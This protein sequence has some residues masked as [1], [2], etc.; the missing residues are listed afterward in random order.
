MWSFPDDGRVGKNGGPH[1][2]LAGKPVSISLLPKKETRRISC[3]CAPGGCSTRGP[4][5]RNGSVRQLAGPFFRLYQSCGISPPRQHPHHIIVMDEFPY[6]ISH[7][8]AIPSI[9]Q[10]IW[11]RILRDVPVLLILSGRLARW[12]LPCSGY[13]SPLYGRGPGSGRSNPFHFL[14]SGNFFPGYSVEEAVQGLVFVLGGI[15]GY[16]QKFS[17]VFPSGRTY[18][19]T[20]LTRGR[21]SIPRRTFS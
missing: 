13:Q 6:L 11:D 1:P 12:N 7:N 3:I 16:L 20:C 19:R 10:G 21:T 2:V 17:R 18:A 5:F 14:I 4:E 15:P 9:F 8:P